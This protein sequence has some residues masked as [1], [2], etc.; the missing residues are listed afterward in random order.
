MTLVPAQGRQCGIVLIAALFMIVV[1]AGLGLFAIRLSA[2]QQQS[3]NLALLGV[4]A[5]AAA[6]SGIQL[7]A[8]RALSATGCAPLIPLT[9][10]VIVTLTEAALNGF[11]VSVTCSHSAHTVGTLTYDVFRLDAFAQ[12]GTYGTPAY[13]ARRASRTVSTSH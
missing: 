6:D 13:V 7:G 1:L 10:T 5:Q 8:Y 4:R 2:S 11:N 3:I 9:T 12:S